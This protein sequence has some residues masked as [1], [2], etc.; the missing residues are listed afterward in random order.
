M[1]LL[2]KFS[3]LTFLL[4]CCSSAQA[5][6]AYQSQMDYLRNYT[7]NQ[8]INYELNSYKSDL[9]GENLSLYNGTLRFERQDAVIP[10]NSNLD[11]SYRTF[12]QTY[13]PNSLGWEENIP[14][15][16]AFSAYSH[17]TKKSSLPTDWQLG[18]FCSGNIQKS[19]DGIDEEASRAF[20][21]TPRIVIPG[22]GSEALLF[23]NGSIGKSTSEYRFITR[24]KWIVSCYSEHG[25]EGFKVNLPNGHIYYFNNGDGVTPEKS[26]NVEGAFMVVLPD[27]PHFREHTGIYVSKI[28]DRFGNRLNYKYS[29]KGLKS[30]SSNDGRRIEVHYNGQEKTV[31]ATDSTN[32]YQKKWI[33]NNGVIT[34]PDGKKWEYNLYQIDAW[35]S[36]ELLDGGASNPPCILFSQFSGTM[37]VKHPDGAVGEFS[38]EERFQN[39]ARDYAWGFLAPCYKTYSLVKKKIKTGKEELV[40]E[41][42]YSSSWRSGLRQFKAGD[43][44]PEGYKIPSPVPSNVDR[45]LT[46]TT[47]ITSPNQDKTIHYINRDHYSY[48]EGTTVAEEVY[49]KSGHLLRQIEY[50]HKRSG[51]YGSRSVTH[52]E[53]N[54]FLN[55]NAAIL[56]KTKTSQSGDIF[57]KKINKFDSFDKPLSITETSNNGEDVRYSL[58]YDNDRTHW[59]LSKL[60]SKDTV[61]DGSFPDV[62]YSYYSPESAHASLLYQV[63]KFGKLQA[64]FSE[65]HPDGNIKRIDYDSSGLKYSKL[66]DYYRG[67]ARKITLP[68]AIPNACNTVNGSTTNTMI[69]KLT[70]NGDGTTGSI[71]DFRGHK[72]TYN[73]NPIGWLTKIDY[74]DNKWTDKLINYT[75]VNYGD[76]GIAGSEIVVGQLKQTVTQGNYERV[77]YFDGLLRPTLTKER[78]KSNDDTIRYQQTVYDF[79][80]KP[81]LESFPSGNAS[82][83]MGVET[84]YDALGRVTAIKRQSDDSSTEITYL[85]G[86]RKQIS[87]AN[88][89]ITT[90]TYYAYGHP[91]FNVPTLIEAPDSSDIEISYNKFGQVKSIT[92]RGVTE[93]YLY[94]NHQQLCKTYRPETGVTAFG[95]N[96][97]GQRIWR[98]EGTNGGSDS[99]AASSV[100]AS[101]KVI[102]KYDNLGRLRAQHFPEPSLNKTYSYDLNGNLSSLNSGSGNSA[103]N[104]EY[105]Y[106]SLNLL[107]EETLSMDGKSFSLDWT[108]NNLGALLSLKYPSGRK[109]TYYPNAL[110]QPTKVSEGTVNYTNNVKYHPNGTIKQ[111]TYGNGIVRNINLDTSGRIDEIKDS[112]GA[113]HKLNIDPRYDLNDNVA[114]V[115]DWIDRSNDID[116]MRYDGMNRLLSADGKWG[117]GY[118]HYDGLGNITSRSISG[119]VINYNYNHLNQLDRLTGAYAYRYRYDSRG[120]VIH[121]GRYN[122]NFNH[123]NQLTA[124]KGLAYRYDG[125]NRRVKKQNDYSIYSQGGQ[126][127]HR[128][129]ANGE[130]TDTIYL[131]KQIMAEITL[132]GNNNPPPPELPIA[133]PSMNLIFSA[134][135]VGEGCRKNFGCITPVYPSPYKQLQFEPLPP[136]NL[137]RG[138]YLLSWTTKGAETCSGKV[139]RNGSTSKVLTGTSTMGI[140]F[141]NDGALYQASLTCVGR[142]GST[143]K[144]AIIGGNGDEY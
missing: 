109:V 59:V 30:I 52:V 98:A 84:K 40:W 46:K 69:A 77:R 88:Q 25:R 79:E 136:I 67:R 33:Y 53:G 128:E 138:Y 107:E 112:K 127:L 16:E 65:Y 74:G 47:T 96:A 42:D 80:N 60:K 116:N 50:S 124:A 87:D 38:F 36:D 4:I 23:N 118:Y 41:Y 131:G 51:T 15:I 29:K 17:V 142:G 114:G 45:H 97:Q 94:D 86:N 10:G 66:E 119:S 44:I 106:N 113:N 105:K 90:S 108:Y 134:N 117:R 14:R 95:Y 91:S 19:R 75:Q 121:N 81:T 122:L 120:N 18:K 111:L 110:G 139:L 32:S 21:T 73:Y 2:R 132:T 26:L 99:C 104:W 43:A 71:T 135:H 83:M 54:S 57:E 62:E 103:I 39:K 24:N 143:T 100:P 61:G 123:A 70:I 129:K 5:D 102:M 93:K 22:I 7:D 125:H 72:T 92:Q 115:I 144:T 133:K 20:H 48:L 76:D 68:C 35:P 130:K 55:N 8:N 78:D 34:R 12:Y 37:R 126:L 31:L 140:N 1:I 9:F 28:E 63:K 49:S 85:S 89:N 3:W 101:H 56:N 141:E 64:T 11:M 13:M 27:S 6:E 82:N 137:T 58:K